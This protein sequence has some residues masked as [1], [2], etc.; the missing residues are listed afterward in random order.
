MLKLK[1]KVFKNEILGHFSSQI[2]QISLILCITLFTGVTILISL[3]SLTD[4]TVG[5]SVSQSVTAVLTLST[6][7]YSVTVSN[8]TQICEHFFS[9]TALRIFPKLGMHDQHDKTKKRTRPFV[10]EKSGSLIIHENRFWPFS[11]VWGRVTT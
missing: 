10:R 2:S 9:K 6:L 1:I 11:Q 7:F 5:Q 3:T 4:L 8:A